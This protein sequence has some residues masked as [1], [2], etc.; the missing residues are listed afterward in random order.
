MLNARLRE[1]TGE[2]R[3][4]DDVMSALFQRAQAP[5]DGGFT[6][7]SLEAVIDSICA[8]RMDAFFD[9]QIRG[10]GPVDVT[11][12]V[13]RLG[14][15]F[16]LDSVPATDSIG[17][18]LPDLRLSTDFAAPAGVQRVVVN[19]PATAWAMAGLR[20]GDELVGLNGAP[21]RTFAELAA[22]LHGLHI[23]DRATV[24]I[25]RGGQ[26]MRVAVAVTGYKRPRVGFVDAA[27]VSPEQ[28]ARRQA[29]LVGR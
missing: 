22:A 21:V 23:G 26:P 3:G 10:A 5:A 19:N 18:L 20:T 12:L 6:S 15:R 1:T 16:V 24:D 25:R 13:A 29:W 4:L 2:R 17:Q 11:P 9:D 7:G 14:L 8:C 28:R 27:D